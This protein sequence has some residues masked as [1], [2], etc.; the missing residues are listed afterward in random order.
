MTPG[1][2]DPRIADAIVERW[3]TRDRAIIAS[4]RLS[5]QV[6]EHPAVC[7]ILYCESA[8]GIGRNI[9][10]DALV[11]AAQ[12]APQAQSAYFTRYENVFRDWLYGLRSMPPWAAALVCDIGRALLRAG[13]VCK[14]DKVI[15]RGYLTEIV[16]DLA[17]GQEAI[18]WMLSAL[19]EIV[20][21]RGARR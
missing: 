18:S 1:L 21:R 6:S 19:D 7:L 10:R 5:G 4:R 17:G 15:L 12:H 3:R 8:L 2:P 16:T 20:E 14:R 9:F 13:W 11:E